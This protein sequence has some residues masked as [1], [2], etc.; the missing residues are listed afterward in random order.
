MLILLSLSPRILVDQNKKAYSA[1]AK[2]TQR[3]EKRDFPFSKCEHTK[4]LCVCVR[5]CVRVHTII[6]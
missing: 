3:A 6:V 2:N 1:K 5:V 4:H